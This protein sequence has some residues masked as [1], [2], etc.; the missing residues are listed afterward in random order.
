MKE[1]GIALL[2]T[3]QLEFYDI[4]SLELDN[5]KI[6]HQGQDRHLLDKIVPQVELLKT[7]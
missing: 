7:V 2:R 6:W 1:I 3:V 4:V 5:P